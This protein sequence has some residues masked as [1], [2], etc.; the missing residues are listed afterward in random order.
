M[1][2]KITIVIFL[3][4]KIAAANQMKIFVEFSSS[5]FLQNKKVPLQICRQPFKWNVIKL[6]Y[7]TEVMY[8]LSAKQIWNLKCNAV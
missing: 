4:I 8:E 5:I 3:S 1:L 2:Y 7:L 6:N